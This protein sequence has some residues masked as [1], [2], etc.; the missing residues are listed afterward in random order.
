MR[1][2]LIMFLHA[3]AVLLLAATATFS[4]TVEVDVQVRARFTGLSTTDPVLAYHA[5]IAHATYDAYLTEAITIP[6]IRNQ[7]GVLPTNMVS[8]QITSATLTTGSITDASYEIL[9]SPNIDSGSEVIPNI[10]QRSNS[11]D[12]GVWMPIPAI[13]SYGTYTFPV[14]GKTFKVRCWSSA[15]PTSVR[16]N[17]DFLF[18]GR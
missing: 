18:I 17:L 11:A 15:V 4:Q 7:S 10:L 12:T 5:S 16:R 9:C 14:Y 6:I 2:H 1:K 13:T 3:V 8:L